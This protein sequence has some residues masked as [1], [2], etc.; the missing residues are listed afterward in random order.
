MA[1]RPILGNHRR[2][3]GGPAGFSPLPS[4]AWRNP[5]WPCLWHFFPEAGGF[6]NPDLRE[7]QLALEQIGDPQ[8]YFGAIEGEHFAPAA[9]GSII[10]LDII[11]GDLRSP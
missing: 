10:Q 6:R 5:S 9:P 11:D 7:H 8:R 2:L 1:R 3:I 4:A